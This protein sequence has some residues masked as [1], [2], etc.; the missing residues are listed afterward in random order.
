MVQK[1][2]VIV[3]GTGPGGEG[4]A[5]QAAKR[6]KTVLVVERYCKVGGG[7][8]HWGTI[9][10]KAL[11]HAIQ[12][13]VETHRHAEQFF[14]QPVPRPT[15]PDLLRL[16]DSVI[17][18]QV[19]M[20]QGFYDRNGVPV[21]HGHARFADAHTVEVEMA[22][23]KRERFEG[24]HFVI[25]TGSRPYRPPDVQ[26]DGVRVCDSDT[27]LQLKE[28]PHALTI[29]GAGVVGCE[30]ASMFRNLGIKVNLINTRDRLLSFL[31]DDIIDALAYHLREHGALIRHNEE[32]ERVEVNGE[33]VV[34]HLKS[35]KQIKSDL[36]LWA[37]GRS[38]NSENMGLEQ[39]GLK[40]DNRGQLQVNDVYQT[41]RKSVV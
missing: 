2:D 4:A 36:L 10:S 9:P 39:L 13:V 6:G 7:C 12:T 3:I 20:R 23:G 28:T 15:Y 29:Y 8:T 22:D 33:G 14:Q 21:V 37:N 11:R 41:D 18:R 27:I 30:Y 34:L 31:D 17:G 26:F 16:A 1:Y 25:A 38:G 19:E 40:I 5:M 32:Y 24:T 35:G